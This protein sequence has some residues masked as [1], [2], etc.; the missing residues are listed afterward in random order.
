MVTSPAA[1][2]GKSTTIANLA[3]ALARS[4]RNV[5]LV[6]LDLRQPM[7]AT[8]FGMNTHPGVTDVALGRVSLDEALFRV[9]IPGPAQRGAGPA[10]GR[11]RVLGS[12]APPPSPGEFVGTQSLAHILERLRAEHDFVLVDAPPLLAV[13]DAITIS[14]RVDAMFALVRLGLTDRQMLRDFSR[15][16]RTIPTHK[17]GFVLT[18]VETRE[19]YGGANYGYL[20]DRP[21]PEGPLPTL[22]D[23]SPPPP[24]VQSDDGEPRDR[25]RLRS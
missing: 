5:A 7:I 11:L 17:L 10:G 3:V 8:F 1:V 23:V 20:R 16:L 4:G 12:G 25:R 18:G 21:T 19:M 24:A 15:A 22:R 6:D 2:Q 13:G 9:R 14:T